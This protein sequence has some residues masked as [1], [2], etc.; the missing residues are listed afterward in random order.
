[1]SNVKN[2]F[3]SGELPF[4]C[5]ENKE[6]QSWLAIMNTPTY[7]LKINWGHYRYVPNKD[8]GQTAMYKFTIGGKE[9]ISF[10]CFDRL[11]K[12][13]KDAGGNI[14]EQDCEDIEDSFST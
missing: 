6:M 11:L 10:T 7:G 14:I 5:N 4:H 3:I 12:D 2:V 9:A 13:I 8:G 1:M